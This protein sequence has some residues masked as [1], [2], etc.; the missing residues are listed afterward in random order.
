MKM[1]FAVL[2]EIDG[3]SVGQ[4]LVRPV[5]WYE[6]TPVGD[7]VTDSLSKKLRLDDVELE[8]STPDNLS[9]IA[10]RHAEIAK[11]RRIDELKRQLK[12]LGEV[13]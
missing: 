1:T 8:I 12:E 4:V 11:T 3:H 10:E 13:A 7:V 6:D 9:E 2:V 5:G